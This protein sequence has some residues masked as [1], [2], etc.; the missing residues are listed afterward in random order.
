MKRIFKLLIIIASLMFLAG[1]DSIRADSI[2]KKSAAFSEAGEKIAFISEQF[3]GTAYQYD[4][5]HGNPDEKEQMV[6]NLTA[7]DCFT[8]LDY[9]EALRL[10]PSVSDFAEKLK[11][12][13]YF[14][15]EVNF[16]KRR[17]FF[18]DWV[19]DDRTSV[20]DITS[21]LPGAVT[22]EKIIN[23]RTDTESWIKHIPHTMR[24]VTYIP[25]FKID[26]NL[27]KLL[28]NGD[29]IGIY[30]DKAGLDVS[31]TGIFIRDKKGAALFRNA[32]SKDMKVTDYPFVKYASE[33]KG[34]VVFRAR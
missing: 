28:K 1:W 23:R 12:V 19:A 7:M 29:Y 14:D 21:D 18:T 16:A 32:S 30:S 11:N 34:I 2:I 6:I 33:S 10:S 27:A 9:V 13:R 15:G 5:L 3:L 26:Q 17:H 22:V 25:G 4:T 8:Y 24:M 31:H 20:Q